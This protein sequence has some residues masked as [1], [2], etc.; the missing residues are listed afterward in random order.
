[1]SGVGARLLSIVAGGIVVVAGHDTAFAS[2]G[3]VTPKG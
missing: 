1:M 3:I 2:P